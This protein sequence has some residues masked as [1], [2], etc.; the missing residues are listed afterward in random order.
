MGDVLNYLNKIAG[1]KPMAIN[2]GMGESGKLFQA[3]A[4]NKLAF[5]F[6]AFGSNE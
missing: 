1:N 2:W 6:E 5:W 4:H 3:G